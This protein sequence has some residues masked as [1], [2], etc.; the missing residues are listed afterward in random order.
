MMSQEQLERYRRMTTGQRLKLTLQ[1]IE[2][3]EPALLHGPE[4][5]VRRR[6]ELI[7]RNND[8]RNE[9]LIEAFA[10]TGHPS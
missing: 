3:N 2:E 8:L 10:R 1:M 7:Q 6:F 9:R 4:E 5:V